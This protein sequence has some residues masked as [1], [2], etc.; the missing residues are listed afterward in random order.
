MPGAGGRRVLGFLSKIEESSLIESWFGVGF[1]Y[2]N[3]A[4]NY[5][6]EVSNIYSQR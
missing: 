2:A 3:I 1:A 5:R 6:G 4:P